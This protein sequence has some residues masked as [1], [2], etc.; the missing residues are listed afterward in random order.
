MGP[1]DKNNKQFFTS[2]FFFVEQPKTRLNMHQSK[3]KSKN[4][5]YIINYA[6][7]F[8]KNTLIFGVHVQ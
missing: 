5:K 1:L 3:F 8:L 6:N 7:F 4:K 2:L